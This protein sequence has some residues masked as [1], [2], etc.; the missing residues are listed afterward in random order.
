[1]L[2]Q[3]NVQLFCSYTYRYPHETA[4]GALLDCQSHSAGPKCIS[5]I[6][7]E[8]FLE[9]WTTPS[10]LTPAA[11]LP[12]FFAHGFPVFC[13]I[14]FENTKLVILPST[15]MEAYEPESERDTL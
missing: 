11:A 2:I 6:C 14:T 15:G 8:R 3:V 7:F 10:A 1:M 13:F 12:P 5:P 4:H 9:V